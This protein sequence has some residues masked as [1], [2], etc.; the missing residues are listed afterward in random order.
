[1]N[2][3]LDKSTEWQVSAQLYLKRLTSAEY[4]ASREDWLK[5]RRSSTTFRYRPSEYVERLVRLLGENDE[6]G[7]KAVKGLEGYASKLGA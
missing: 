6:E 7:F 2:R 4:A 3:N 1:M 5:R